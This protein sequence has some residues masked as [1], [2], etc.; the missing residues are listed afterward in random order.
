MSLGEDFPTG[1][2]QHNTD[3]EPA[4]NRRPPLQAGG[5]VPWSLSRS[6]RRMDGQLGP[7]PLMMEMMSLLQITLVPV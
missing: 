7:R 2:S 1:V 3:R 6:L 5:K 4:E